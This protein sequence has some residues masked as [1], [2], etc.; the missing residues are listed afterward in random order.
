MKSL[1][2]TWASG[3]HKHGLPVQSPHV[4]FFFTSCMGDGKQIPVLLPST[5]KSRAGKI[6]SLGADGRIPLVQSRIAVGRSALH[7]HS[8]PPPHHSLFDL[9]TQ[10]SCLPDSSPDSADIDGL[11]AWWQRKV[12]SQLLEEIESEASKPFLRLC[13]HSDW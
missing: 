6:K 3:L 5:P 13:S 9:T 8:L 1:C 2:I 7:I 10:L 4:P 12:S 11:R